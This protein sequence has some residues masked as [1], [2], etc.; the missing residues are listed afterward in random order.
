MKLA[1]A[2]LAALVA[3]S[4]S[5]QLK[6]DDVAAHYSGQGE[7]LVLLNAP[8]D[9]PDFPPSEFRRLKK[10]TYVA[11]MQIMNGCYNVV[12]PDEVVVVMENGALRAMHR[13]QFAKWNI[14]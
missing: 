3:T 12:S 11:Y 8:C 7:T 5:A 13:R 14:Q 10:A 6:Y 9:M 2:A 1:I 4:A